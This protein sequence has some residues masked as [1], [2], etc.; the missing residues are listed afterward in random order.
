MEDDGAFRAEL[1][2][3]RAGA[4]RRRRVLV[5]PSGAGPVVRV[6]VEAPTTER[7]GDGGDP[8]GRRRQAAPAELVR[9]YDRLSPES[10]EAREVGRRFVGLGDLLAGERERDVL[11]RVPRPA[12]RPVPWRGGCFTTMSPST[13][14]ATRAA[15]RASRHSARRA[16]RNAPARRRCPCGRRAV[17][18]FARDALNDVGGRDRPQGVHVAA[19]RM[20]RSPALT[21]PVRSRS[22]RLPFLDVPLRVVRSPERCGYRR[23]LTW[24]FLCVRGIVN[25]PSCGSRAAGCRRTAPPPRR[26]RAGHRDPR[27]RRHGRRATR[28]TRV[29]ARWKWCRYALKGSP[30]GEASSATGPVRRVEHH[31]EQLQLATDRVEA[32]LDAN[33]RPVDRQL[34]CELGPRAA[35]GRSVGGRPTGCAPRRRRSLWL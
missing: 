3:R 15:P 9:S 26:A 6:M 25:W 30:E 21:D 24:G 11:L 34:R 1:G 16:G 22:L 7:G 19:C 17:W 33:G 28:V 14:V 23:P 8:F 31:V 35:Q 27:D 20:P 10:V 2:D 5:R 18:L 32:A 13:L 4:R 12:T 29:A